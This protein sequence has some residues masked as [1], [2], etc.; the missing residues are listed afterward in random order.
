M[1]IK[2]FLEMEP[3]SNICDLIK[4]T[5]FLSTLEGEKYMFD[6]L[7]KER[8]FTSVYYLLRVSLVD[9]EIWDG[10]IRDVDAFLDFLLKDGKIT[11]RE[12]NIL[13]ETRNNKNEIFEFLL[14]EIRNM[15][16]DDLLIEVTTDPYIKERI[17]DI[18]YYYDNYLIAKYISSSESE[19]NYFFKVVFNEI[20]NIG[21]CDDCDSRAECECHNTKN[22]FLLSEEQYELDPTFLEKLDSISI[23]FS[24]YVFEE[25]EEDEEEYKNNSNNLFDEYSSYKRDQVNAS[26]SNNSNDILSDVEKIV[27]S[28]ETHLDYNLFIGQSKKKLREVKD[29]LFRILS[30]YK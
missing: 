6:K 12:Y 26:K 27:K 24:D 16:D 17:K 11:E 28:I 2:N 1:D 20:E 19:M 8:S 14:E 29:D 25:E 9:Y 7:V 23:I 5:D 15:F 4:M 22:V 3:I 30:K 10:I 21:F 18:Y 13:K